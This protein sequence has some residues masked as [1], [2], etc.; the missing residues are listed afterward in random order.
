MDNKYN[1]GNKHGRYL[2]KNKGNILANKGYMIENEK[3]S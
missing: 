1:F 3:I 2:N